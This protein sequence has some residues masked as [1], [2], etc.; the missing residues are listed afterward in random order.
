MWTEVSHFIPVSGLNQF[1]CIWAIRRSQ[2]G[3]WW[4]GSVSKGRVFA[5]CDDPG[6]TARTHMI[7]EKADFPKLSSDLYMLAMFQHKINNTCKI[8]FREWRHSSAVKRTRCSCRGFRF[9]SQHQYDGLQLYKT[10]FP[11]DTKLSSDFHWAWGTYVM[12]IHSGKYSYTEK[13]KY[14]HQ[15]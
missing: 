1:R 4:Y 15:K 14:T 10:L 2:F 3:G 8:K 11:G 5:M 6:S 13:I 7:I 12:H 9:G